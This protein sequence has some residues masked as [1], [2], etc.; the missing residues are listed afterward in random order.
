LEKHGVRLMAKKK[1]SGKKKKKPAE[2][3]GAVSKKK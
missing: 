3:K 1:P 2:T